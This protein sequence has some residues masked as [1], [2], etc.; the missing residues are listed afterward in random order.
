MPIVEA[1][2]GVDV[3]MRQELAP[4]RRRGV[5]GRES[6]RQ[7][8]ADASSASGQRQCALDEHLVPVDVAGALMPIHAGASEKRLFGSAGA[9]HVPRRVSNDRVEAAIA[10]RAVP[11]RRTR[12]REIRASSGRNGACAPPDRPR[13]AAPTTVFPEGRSDDRSS[14]VG[15]RSEDRRIRRSTRVGPHPACTPEIGNRLPSRAPRAIGRAA[16]LFRGRPRPCRHVCLRAS[17]ARRRRARARAR[18]RH[19]RTAAARRDWCRRVRRPA[20]AAQCRQEMRRCRL[21]PHTR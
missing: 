14:A 4:Q 16:V 18:D 2:D 21:L 3:R 19:R 11:P 7:H 1:A 20:V 17:G 9:Q 12:P 10:A 6:R 8:E 15:E 5:I 13:Q